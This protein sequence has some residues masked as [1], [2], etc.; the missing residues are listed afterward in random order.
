MAVKLMLM[1]ALGLPAVYGQQCS[2]GHVF[3]VSLEGVECWGLS[4][5]STAISADSCL[6]N[7]CNNATCAVW[8]WHPEQKC[9]RGATYQTCRPVANWSGGIVN[10]G[11]TIMKMQPSSAAKP[12]PIAANNTDPDGNV[13][14]VDS[15]SY[16]MNGERFYPIGTLPIVETATTISL[17][18]Y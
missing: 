6:N 3:P 18:M 14:S 1:L 8:N 9:W 2:N 7:C 15:T 17:R 16:L 13:F 5:D 11:E 4:L 10:A 12:L